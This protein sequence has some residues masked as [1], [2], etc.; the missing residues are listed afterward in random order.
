MLTVGAQPMCVKQ[1]ALVTEKTAAKKKENPKQFKLQ[2]AENI[3]N[4]LLGVSCHYMLNSKQRET[5]KSTSVAVGGLS[6]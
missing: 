2:R 1:G 5:N 6:D 3:A 4:I